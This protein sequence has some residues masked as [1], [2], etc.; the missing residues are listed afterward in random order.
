MITFFLTVAIRSRE[1]FLVPEYVT[2]VRQAIQKNIGISLWLIETFSNQDFIKEFLIDC[3]IHDMSRF[4]N[5]LLK[6]AM[7]Q[8]Y[9]FEKELI[10]KYSNALAENGDDIMKFVRS[11]QQQFIEEESSVEGSEVNSGSSELT[12]VKMKAHQ[13]DLPKLVILFNSVTHITT[14][15]YF[16]NNL[17]MTGIFWA[18]FSNFTYLGDEMRRYMLLTKTLGRLLNLFLRISD[19]K[20]YQR[21]GGSETQTMF[22]DSKV[23]AK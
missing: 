10:D 13:N 1:R 3:P 4:V 23:L 15:S 20:Y 17:R 18:I 5:G 8:V 19:E 12:V 22:K 21:Q 7:I 16:L 6:T 2:L 14:S 9:E 11:T